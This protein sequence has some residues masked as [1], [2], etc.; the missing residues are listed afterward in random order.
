M[1]PGYTVVTETLQWAASA[2]SDRDGKTERHPVTYKRGLLVVAEMG[3]N[4]IYYI[5][6]NAIVTPEALIMVFDIIIKN[7]LFYSIYDIKI[8]CQ[9]FPCVNKN[10]KTIRL[11]KKCRLLIWSETKYFE[12]N[13]FCMF[14]HILL[15]G[16][17]Y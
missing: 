4:C 5:S 8:D 7:G 17:L 9:I 14:I 15:E 10:I 1:Q 13:I 6:F 16:T 12:F 2:H 3:A 11:A